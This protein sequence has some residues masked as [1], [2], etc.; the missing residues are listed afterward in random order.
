MDEAFPMLETLLDQEDTIRRIARSLLSDESQVDDVV[1]EAWLRAYQSPPRY[2]GGL[3]AWLSTVTRRIA[4]K[5]R[6]RDLARAQRE[7]RVARDETYPSPD[8]ILEREQIRQQLVNVLL[9]PLVLTLILIDRK[10]LAL[11]QLLYVTV[12]GG[13]CAHIRRNRTND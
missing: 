12:V 10:G 1:Q 2:S 6:R 7:E 13:D 3:R 8:V 9:L 4:S 5:Q 11:Q